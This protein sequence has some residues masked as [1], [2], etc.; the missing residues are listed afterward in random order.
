MRDPQGLSLKDWGIRVVLILC[1]LA[2]GAVV[3]LGAVS[4]WVGLT[5]LARDGF[6]V[7]VTAGLLAIIL[8]TA[9]YVRLSR[10]LLGRLKDDDIL[11]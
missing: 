11:G 7:P 1:G 4:L 2:A 10:C 8:V 6:W 3:F 9:L 5:H